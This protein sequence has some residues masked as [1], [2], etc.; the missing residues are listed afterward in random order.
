[1]SDAVLF[2]ARDD[3]IAVITIRLAASTCDQHLASGWAMPWFM[4]MGR[5]NTTR[6][7]A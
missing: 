2:D 3:G 1:M 7:R 6:S 4:P 5:S